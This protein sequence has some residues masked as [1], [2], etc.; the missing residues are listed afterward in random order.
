MMAT[1]ETGMDA[2]VVTIPVGEPADEATTAEVIS[3][4]QAVFACFSAGDSLTAYGHFSENLRTLF[5]PEPNTP[6]EEAEA[7][8]TGTPMPEDEEEVT[9]IVA[10]TD[11]STLPDGRIGAFVIEETGG[12]Y[13]TSHATFIYEG[14]RL[15]VDNVVEFTIFEDEE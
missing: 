6:I 9:T 3:V 12:Q 11:V 10:I 15:V 2:G 1:P 5:G 8:L 4:V 7:F 14:E 13:L